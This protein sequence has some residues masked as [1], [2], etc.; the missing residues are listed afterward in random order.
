MFASHARDS[1]NEILMVLNGRNVSTLRCGHCLV[2]WCLCDG[3]ILVHGALFCRWV[4]V[5]FAH[6]SRTQLDHDRS[7]VPGDALVIRASLGVRLQ[8]SGVGTSSETVLGSG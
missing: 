1:K 6:A 5:I 2:L 8:L 7:P 4:N 3:K